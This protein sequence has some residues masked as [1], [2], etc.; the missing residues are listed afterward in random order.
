MAYQLIY[1]SVPRGLVPGRSGYTVAARH[2]QIRDR[3]VS[4][5]E[6]VSRY[7][8]SKGGE[9]PVV[10]AH[11]IFDISGS[12]FHVLTRIVDAGSDYTG[13]TNYLAHHLICDSKE[14]SSS[15]THPAEI[16]LSF[17]WLD[18]F[19][20]EPKYLEDSDIVDLSSYKGNIK[21]PAA[22]WKS[23]RG[24]A[25]DAALLVD[26]KSKAKNSILVFEE[27]D[28][29]I[30]KRLILLVGESAKLL[31]SPNEITF[32][33]F[34][35]EGDTMSDF[36][37]IGCES[38]SSMVQ[39]PTN[40]DVV[41][42]N[43]IDQKSP[44]T[45]L[46]QLAV[47]GVL[48]PKPTVTSRP[49]KQSGSAEF[50]SQDLR[51]EQKEASAK[52][53]TGSLPARTNVPAPSFIKTGIGAS[54]VS[55]IARSGIDNADEVPF[56]IKNLKLIVISSVVGIGII[57]GLF[58]YLTSFQPKQRIRINIERFANE[59]KYL[60]ANDYLDRVLNERPN[61]RE[62]I[63]DTRIEKVFKPMRE[64]TELKINQFIGSD[65]ENKKV[66]YD[67][68]RNQLDE[69]QVFTNYF[70]SGSPEAAKIY[71]LIED[72]NNAEKRYMDSLQSE[73]AKNNTEKE[74][75]PKPDES[76][77]Q[78]DSELASNANEGE[79]EK[80]KYSPVSLYIF[81][82]TGN[83]EQLV[84]P[85]SLRR[86]SE[87]D[88][89][90]LMVKLKAY[91]LSNNDFPLSR[92]I[93]SEKI[94]Y[95]FP[96]TAEEEN[97]EMIPISGSINLELKFQ[98]AG[99]LYLLRRQFKE[100]DIKSNL[101]GVENSNLISFSEG[102]SSL[103]VLLWN[104][105]PFEP[106]DTHFKYTEGRISLDESLNR[107]INALGKAE[108]EQ[109]SPNKV[110]LKYTPR[111]T[112][113]DKGEPLTSVIDLGVGRREAMFINVQGVSGGG[114]EL[115]TKIEM[116]IDE[117]LHLINKGGGEY[118]KWRKDAA[119]FEKKLR[120][121]AIYL[122]GR[123]N[124]VL[125]RY[126]RIFDQSDQSR[127]R[128]DIRNYFIALIQ[129]FAENLRDDGVK[130]EDVDKI[131]EELCE[132]EFPDLWNSLEVSAND[133]EVFSEFI[134]D[135]ASECKDLSKRRLFGRN[136][137]EIELSYYINSTTARKALMRLSLTMEN[138]FSGSLGEGLWNFTYQKRPQAPKNIKQIERYQTEIE[139]LESKKKEAETALKNFTPP[140]KGE[141]PEGKYE[142]LLVFGDGKP[143]PFI[144][145]EINNTNK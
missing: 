19:E 14:L 77:P 135:F 39:K 62:R 121:T 132:A 63:E 40:R 78:D 91:G 133:G 113:A 56:Y 120:D 86:L 116:Q 6:R 145:T 93:K 126:R 69:F 42:L 119:P 112:G 22:N 96:E 70:S 124:D 68:A 33:T 35:Q 41:N 109:Y 61:W 7:S 48:A 106:L 9:S 50:A 101:W 102:R 88:Q 79:P 110:I 12:K 17:D 100:S 60:E 123:N 128:T 144:L 5:I 3:L 99:S 44:D 122:L 16:L 138:E 85:E 54:P 73:T 107:V 45:E 4:E 38:G 66:R 20:G 71:K 1:T 125:T 82:N 134:D 13:R 11:R 53:N 130:R 117:R 131:K 58:F 143:R 34:F 10:Y 64:I 94:K 129:E 76:S 31:S 87:G 28:R 51:S 127:V 111:G 49:K 72:Y 139:T 18:S 83:F 105:A 27:S 98:G 90:Q 24:E 137:R 81:L 2:R 84:L 103:D 59:Q 108:P 29:S 37:W 140:K 52:I 25:A 8:Y 30:E 97:N 118:F 89:G 21:L 43:N 141:L 74:I 55:S 95:K 26:T 57:S 65:T 32:T 23:L 92:I 136:K 15:G 142:I 46:A 80:I 47:K 67:I 75:T 114:L 115:L 36:Q 104:G